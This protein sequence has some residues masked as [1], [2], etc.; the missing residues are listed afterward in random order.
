M[1]IQSHK[2]FNYEKARL[3]YTKRY[4]EY[5][6][7][8]ITSEKEVRKESIK[9]AMV[10]FDLSDS[11]QRYT[12]V[13]LNNELIKLGAQDYNGLVRSR[14][15]PYFG[16]VDFREENAAVLSLLHWKVGTCQTER[17]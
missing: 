10:E 6:I 8:R 15:K 5:F 4:I 7:K 3:K 11:S 13:L 12:S 9:Q 1:S 16:R 2:D 14:H 17:E